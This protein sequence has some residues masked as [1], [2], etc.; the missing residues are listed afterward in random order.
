MAH[1]EQHIVVTGGRPLHGSVR[2]P[3]A[4]N[5]VL[6]LLAASMLCTGGVRLT[7]VPPL[8]DVACGLELLRSAGCRA[9][10]RDGV[11]CVSGPPTRG[12]LAEETARQMRASILFC[13]PLLARL[14]RAETV[15]PGGCDLGA[16]PIDLHLAGLVQMGAQVWADDPGR[17]VLTAPAG[18]HGAELVLHFPSV[19]AT[20]TLLLAAAC[21]RGTTILRGAAREPEIVDLARFLNCCGACI[22]GAGGPVLRIE[23]RRSLGGCSYS[24]VPDRIFA[25]TLACAAAAAG[26][27]VE[28]AAC[29]PDLYA[30]ALD[31]LEAMGCRIERGA[32]AV[33][34]ARFGRL[35]GVGRVFT[36]VYPALATDAAPPLAAAMLCAEGESSIEDVVFERRFACA[37]GFTAMGAQAVVTGRTLTVRGTPLHAATVDAP[38][39]RGGAALVIAALAAKGSS[40]IRRTAHIDRGYADLAET[41]AALGAQISCK[42]AAGGGLFKKTSTKNE[43]HLAIGAK[44]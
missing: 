26:G 20:E 13:A 25:A 18:L 10:W 1:T 11:V 27:Q 17:L 15:L 16:R 35:H 23:G 31:I 6:P 33:R 39:L 21:A 9:L 40:V 41:L 3:A 36:G 22:E 19:G 43:I 34:V 38:D 14:G 8:S 30:P 4:K 7:G 44:R 5:S 12:T 42:M 29:P 37:E 2:V 24:P 28:L 32:S